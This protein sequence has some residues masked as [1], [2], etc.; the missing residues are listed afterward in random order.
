MTAV[1]APPAPPFPGS[2][3]TAE[4]FEMIRA[5]VRRLCDKYGNAYWRGLE[6]DLYPEEFVAELTEQG[7]LGALIHLDVAGTALGSDAA[8]GP[9]RAARRAQKCLGLPRSY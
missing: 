7:W 6:P 1:V 9:D 3:E 5:E 4:D 2:V 8:A